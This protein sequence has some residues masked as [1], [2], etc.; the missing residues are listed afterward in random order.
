MQSDIFKAY[1]VRAVYPDALDEHAAYYIGHAFAAFLGEKK[2]IV[3]GMDVRESGPALFDAFA[4]GVSAAGGSVVDIGMVT[5]EMMYFAVAQYGYDGGVMVSASHN[6]RQYNGFKF[7]REGARAISIETGLADIR[8]RALAHEGHA[9]SDMGHEATPLDIWND[10]IDMML[11]FVDGK[12]VKPF[13]VVAS[14]NFGMAGKVITRLIE[15]GK[16]PITIIPIDFEPDGSFPK[17]KPDPLI[18]E[19]RQEV[20]DRIKKEKPDFG[21]AWDAD[22]DRIFFFDERGGF[23]HG[24]YTISLLARYLLEKYPGEKVLYDVR[25]VWASASTIRDAGG[26][27]IVMKPGHSFIK[28]RMRAEQALFAG[29]NSGHFYFRD[30]FGVDSGMVP[31]LLMLDVLSQRDAT[32]SSLVDDLRK[33]FPI[34]EEI[35]SRVDDPAS[36]LAHVEKQFA[37][38]RIEKIDGLSVEYP[39]WRFNL[40]PSNTEPVIRLNVEAKTDALVQEKTDTLLSFIRA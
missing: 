14:A 30:F 7:V 9:A 35:N 18:P 31:F 11:T 39:D 26:V 32:L 4:R 21:L 25:Q 29:E 37:D 10:Y 34:S 5:T 20:I 19:R 36:V 15:R 24:Y 40:R 3:L 22:A 27:P 12:K 1:D 16:L 2:K 23:V 33:R 6:E 17:G 13:T 8:D 38:G 28:D